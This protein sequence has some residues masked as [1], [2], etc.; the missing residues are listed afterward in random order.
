MQGAAWI[1]LV[2]KALRSIREHPPPARLIAPLMCLFI[3]L[4]IAAPG[5]GIFETA[6][7]RVFD[8]YQ[9]FDPVDRPQAKT[10]LIDI[11]AESLRRLGQ[12]PWPRDRLAHLIDAAAGAKVI[13]LDLLLVEPDRTSPAAWAAD[14]TDLPPDAKQALLALP[15]TDDAL[16]ASIAHAPVV[17][18]AAADRDEAGA[19][20][21][22]PITP[23]LESGADLRTDLQ[24]YSA[25]AWPLPVLARNA[26]GIGL[27]SVLPEPDGV[28]RR[29]PAVEV[30]GGTLV[31]SFA[32]EMLRVA[33]GTDHI[34]LSTTPLGDRVVSVG[35]LEV[36]ADLSGRIWP[37]YG[38]GLRGHAIPA[39]RVLSG[40]VPPASFKGRVVLIATGA[41][42]L[43]DVMATPLHRSETGM[44]VEAN[45]IESM[46]DGDTLRRPAL[47][48]TSEMLSALALGVAAT[49][50]I[51]R[52]TVR[53]YMLLFG[54]LAALL[55]LVSVLAFLAGWLID[56]SLPLTAL[57]ATMLVAL[58][59]RIRDETRAR[60][61]YALDLAAALLHAEA[62]DRA[63]TE[64]LANASH[65]LRTPLTAIIGFSEVMTMEL[66]GPILKTYLDYSRDIHSSATHLLSIISDMLDLTVIDLGGRKPAD[67]RIQVTHLAAE[68]ERMILARSTGRRVNLVTLM[69]DGLPMLLADARMVRQMLLNLLSNAVKYSPPD[70]EVVLAATIDAGGWLGLSVRDQGPGIPAAHLPLILQ[71]FARLRTAS[72]AQEPGIGIGLPL[73]KSMIELH[74]G[75]LEIKSEVAAGT[76]AI[77][78]FPPA[79]LIREMGAPTCED[80]R[81]FS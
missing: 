44:M 28:M 13:G 63:K 10:V 50:L 47:A 74:G 60:R 32:V 7:D 40:V 15:V 20:L 1:G 77:L 27:V 35:P 25:V 16:A 54:G 24:H 65:E 36:P 58:A 64:F 46:L 76:E 6:R 9:R 81:Q 48:F 66:F 4:A 29:L 69:P 31:P 41:A 70:G 62:A 71:R 19:P 55:M 22:R 43:A 17:L 30:L 67:D 11:D 38:I 33:T 79:R 18:A 23:V 37:R 51:G 72:L 49:L 78:H 8:T 59:V 52:L 2:V 14:R 21:A 42:G 68:C 3:V 39:Y 12:W 34:G 61:Q 57:A 45:L 53:N 75:K 5:D 26:A 73:T 80:A 56:W